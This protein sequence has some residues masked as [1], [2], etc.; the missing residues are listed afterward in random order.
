MNTDDLRAQLKAAG[1][2]DEEIEQHLKGAST[3]PAPVTAPRQ[4]RPAAAPATPSRR[5][6]LTQAD[7]AQAFGSGAI[8]G[9]EMAASAMGGLA[10]AL[11][12][13]GFKEGYRQTYAGMAESEKLARRRGDGMM[14]AANIAGSLATAPLMPAKAVATL[15]G[16]ALTFGGMEAVRQAGRAGMEE[17]WGWRCGRSGH[18]NWHDRYPPCCGRRAG[19]PSRS[20]SARWRRLGAGPRNS[21][22]D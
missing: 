1:F 17:A 9:F 10:S 5:P 19:G 18:W 11:Q 8:P 14:T 22:D 13:K 7:Y 4:D 16:R 20:A 2:S 15:G 6:G 3:T 12:G 21:A